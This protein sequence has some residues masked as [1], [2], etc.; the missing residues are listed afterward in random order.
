MDLKKESP[1]EAGQC[2]PTAPG[3]FTNISAQKAI[4][5]RKWI[6]TN[7]QTFTDTELIERFNIS[8]EEAWQIYRGNFEVILPK[9]SFYRAPVT[10]KNQQPSAEIDLL[11]LFKAISGTHYKGLTELYRSMEPG[12]AKAE[13]KK[14]K[15][16]FVSFAGTFSS[17]KIDGLKEL[18][19]YCVLDFD[20]VENPEALK[21]MLINDELLDVQLAFISPSADGVKV[22]VF[23]NS[24]APYQAF[25]T[26]LV[27][28]IHKKYPA[29][30][31]SLDLK[32]KDIPR[33]T[34]V[35]FDQNVYIKSQYYAFT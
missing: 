11:R 20:H 9:F 12:A 1:T 18:S 8:I 24:S 22:V 35:C 23:N 5:I 17:R 7:F 29:L 19:G 6:N 15:F 4:E 27:N 25:Y 3:K 33:A 28:Y 26:A 32:N 2:E 34:F 31:P 30:K 16:D 13:F 10:K 14:T 21:T